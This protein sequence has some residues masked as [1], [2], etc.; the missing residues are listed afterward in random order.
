MSLPNNLAG[1]AYAWSLAVVESMIQTG[2][3]G[4]L[5]R[6]LDRIATSPS[7][8]AAVRETLHSDYSDL[9]QQAITYLKREYLR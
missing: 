9:E 8:E 6:L 4:D 1:F 5:S 3:V 2:G 7:T